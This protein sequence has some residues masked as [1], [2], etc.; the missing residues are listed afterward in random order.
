MADE[1]AD[2]T[3]EVAESQQADPR[4]NP[5]KAVGLLLRA[6][7]ESVNGIK[8]Q[9][10]AP[11]WVRMARIREFQGESDYISK[12]VTPALKGFVTA[13]GYLAKLTLDAKDLLY[14]SDA[15]KALV[16]VSAEFLKT[17]TQ[18]DFYNALLEVAG[19]P[20]GSNPLSGVGGVI[21][22]VVDIAD[23]VPEPEDLQAI[24]REL[25]L[26]L[27]V[28]QLPLDEVGLGPT[29]LA[30]VNIESTGKI[31]LLAWALNEPYM[32]RGLGSNRPEQAVLRLGTRR[33]WEAPANELPGRSL[34]TYGTGDAK[35]TLFE[36][37]FTGTDLGADL[38]EAN[39]ILE[40]L[41][42]VEP[43]VA[44][45]GVFGPELARRLRRFQKVNRIPITGALDNATINRFANLDYGARDLVRAKGFDAGALDGFDD[46]RNPEPAAPSGEAPD[47]SPDEAE[48]AAT[49][50]AGDVP[51][52]PEAKK[53]KT[54][55]KDKKPSESKPEGQ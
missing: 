36:F 5:F 19:Q 15:A 37:R 14:Q 24:G 29:T 18:D 2:S 42:Y 43:E 27:C 22:T 54:G 7:R 34:G 55:A 11:R 20:P 13:L 51:A 52:E 38:G 30:H 8:R 25:Y 17:V 32:V 48:E 41:G 23:K 6:V 9:G 40:T 44:D 53:P 50:P 12:G 16:E 35:E 21:D 28:D 1:T 33:V 47:A 49:E 39:A 26:L 10:Q 4:A 45:K 46:T 31:R 3:T